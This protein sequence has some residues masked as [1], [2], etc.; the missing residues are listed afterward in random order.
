MCLNPKYI[1]NPTHSFIEGMTKYKIQVP[2]GVCEEC[3]NLQKSEWFIRSYC[4][5]LSI[6]DF[7]SCFFL[8]F[9]F[10]DCP[11]F[12]AHYKGY[13][14]NENLGLNELKDC[15]IETPAFSYDIVRAFIKALRKLLEKSYGNDTKL[16][17][18]MFPEYGE[19]YHRPHY[20]GLFFINKKIDSSAFFRLC[21]GYDNDEY[22]R[23]FYNW[24]KSIPYFK[25]KTSPNGLV[26][27][28]AWRYGWV[29]ASTPEKGGITVNSYQSIL[30]CSK[31]A[32][33]DLSYF[34]KDD[35][36]HFIDSVHD[37]SIHQDNSVYDSLKVWKKMCPRHFQSNNLGFDY[38]ENFVKD[39][40]IQ[41][42]TQGI[43]VLRGQKKASFYTI[44][45]YYLRKLL[46]RTMSF[47][48]ED[49]TAK[50]VKWIPR[51]DKSYLHSIL[52]H[53]KIYDS[54]K[55]YEPS[56]IFAQLCLTSDDELHM[57]NL[58]RNTVSN[59]V[60]S[61]LKSH[62]PLC[63]S[64][65]KHV[66]QNRDCSL[67]LLTGEKNPNFTSDYLYSNFENF[68]LK[69]SLFTSLDDDLGHVI[70]P[71][72]P[73]SQRVLFNDL[74][75]FADLDRFINVVDILYSNNRYFKYEYR[76]YLDAFKEQ[77]TNNNH[78]LDISISQFTF[79]N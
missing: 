64:I 3:R 46:Y 38:I 29:I 45:F 51:Q 56:S 8:T 27:R 1:D 62:T 22:R 11:V 74:P 48:K 32:C 49:G 37:A 65:Y 30:Y 79:Q 36:K 18:I 16:K 70:V 21:D 40:P 72:I 12:K 9:T 34:E 60:D 2:C 75:F 53:K 25:T 69:M 67:D 47:D 33:K 71:F 4:E 7:G 59:I 26:S 24:S 42:L 44:P 14:Y 41:A 57:Y 13:V 78:T 28:G 61:V 19:T 39:N 76:D 20:H 5:Y 68:Y 43:E 31:Y 15:T 50:I 35:V 55:K 58:D 54:K 10:A 17:Y 77:F 73:T 6:K 52:L 66:F 23:R 63:I